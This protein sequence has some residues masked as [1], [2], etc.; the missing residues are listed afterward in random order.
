MLNRY[1]NLVRDWEESADI[2]QAVITQPTLFIG[3]ERDSAVV[4]G[5]LEPMKAA[6]PGLRKITLLPGCGHWVQQERAVEVSEALVEFVA[7][8]SSW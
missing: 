2:A 6:V 3:G 8:E 7:Q 1:R 4:F 5:S